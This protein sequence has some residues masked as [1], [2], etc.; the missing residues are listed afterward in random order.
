MIST[1]LKLLA[2]NVLVRKEREIKNFTIRFLKNLAF[3]SPFSVVVAK[4]ENLPSEESRDKLRDLRKKAQVRDQEE[5]DMKQT[6]FTSQQ[7]IIK[8]DTEDVSHHISLIGG[9]EIWQRCK[10]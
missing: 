8:Y 2:A 4:K 7:K 3:I 1:A 6:Q 10:I 9:G 5:L